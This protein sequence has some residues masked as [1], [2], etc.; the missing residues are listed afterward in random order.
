MDEYMGVSATTHEYLKKNGYKNPTSPT[1]NPYTYYH[2]TGGL[3]IFEWMAKHPE[4]LKNFNLAMTAGSSE[5]AGSVSLFP[6]KQTLSQ[7][8][9]TVDTPLVVDVGGGRGH[10]AQMIREELD[11]VPGRVI[12]EDQASAI[13]EVKDQLPDIEKIAQNFFEPQPAGARGAKIYFLRRILHDWGDEACVKILRQL[14]DVMTPE[15]R[16]VI[17]EFLMPDA[18]AGPEACW[19]D[20]VMLTF[21]GTERTAGQFEELFHAAGMELVK[22]HASKTTDYVSS[23]RPLF[24]LLLFAPR[25]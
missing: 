2:K 11:G 24:L 4:R 20:F 5:G 1:D 23:S 17:N 8:R 9:T 25:G 16:V 18:G 3:A 12:L 22:I 7:Y 19:A 15:S 6:F 21:G 13:A 14:A 10:A